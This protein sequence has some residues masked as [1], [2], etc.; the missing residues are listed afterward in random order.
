M[1]SKSASS[2]RVPLYILVLGLLVGGLFLTFYRHYVFDVPWLPDAKRQIWSIEAKIDFEALDQPV[3]LSLAVPDTQPGFER[4]S[5]YTASPGYGLAFI[6][7]GARRRAEW[8]VREANGRQTLYYQVDML[9]DESSFDERYGTPPRIETVTYAGPEQTAV[10]QLSERARERS[11]DAFTMTRELIA[12]FNNESQLAQL[13]VQQK[14]RE[15]RLVEM[16]NLA[17]I[18]AR[19]VQTLFLE[20]G[21]RR[22][23]LVSYLQVF[24]GNE[25]ALFN[26]HTGQQGQQSNQ[27]LWEH[28]SSSLLDL[29]GGRDSGV[30]FSIIAQ[31][32]PASR[33]YQE[34][35][36]HLRNAM[37]FS[38]HS[39][40]LEEQA[41][42][43]GILLIPVGVLVVVIM[44]ILVGIRTSGT[45]MPVLI[46]LAFIQTTL[47]TGL[48]GFFLIVGIGLIIR[49]YLS[50]HN[51]LLVA[52]I[53][54]VIISVI[55]IIA[56]FSILAY[57]LGLVEGLKVTF[58][59]MIIL[60]WTIERMSILWEEEGAKEVFVQGGG[61]L[62]VAVLAYLVMINPIV[63]HLMFNF[64]GLQ[65]VFMALVLM[66]GNYT[67]YRLSELRRFRHLVQGN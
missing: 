16:L 34:K 58:F 11:A 26:P 55:I 21:R 45:F 39:L 25:Y 66:C 1:S 2:N 41:M 51:L 4:M 67:G 49:S 8:S 48:V 60:S 61:S 7:E 37:D 5:E 46:A 6:D 52:R 18:P 33:I 42:F 14:T 57:G 40:P 64:I 22:Q 28:N 12:E 30:S 44:R 56:V 50:R 27:L 47:I 63:R 53:S 19:V 31:E 65:L 24:S 3:K 13:L 29:V 15:R 36:A 43:K 59:P 17:G 62:L 35:V 32:V 23:S 38:I 10:T 54:A 20:D 9:F